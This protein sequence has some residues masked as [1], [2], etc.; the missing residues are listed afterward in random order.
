MRR[1]IVGFALGLLSALFIGSVVSPGQA[2]ER[3][4]FNYGPLDFSVSVRSLEAFA[5]DGTVNSDLA[6]LINRLKPEQREKF[7]SFLTSRYQ[8]SPVLMAQFFYSSLGERLLMYLG[9]L[10]QAPANQNGFYGIRAALI[11]AAA[12]PN[13]F[14]AIGFMQKF[15]TNIRLNTQRIL[16]QW[17]QISAVMQETETYI[18]TLKQTSSAIKATEPAID[19]GKLPNLQ[20]PGPYQYVKQTRTLQDD[21]RQRQ[22]IVDLYLPNVPEG[23]SSPL[24]VFTNGIG[25]RLDLYGYLAQHLAS[26]GFAIAIPQHPGSDDLQQQAFLK[27][28][29]REMF[30][31]TA[32]IDRPLDITYLLNELERLNPSEFKNQLNLK[33]VGI[34]GNSFGGDTALAVAGARMNFK[35]LAADCSPKKNLV[36]LSLLVQCQALQLPHKDYNFR[37]PRIKAASVLFPGSNSL[38]GQN[39]L[40][41]ITIPV[42]WGAVSKDIFSPLVL[43][44]LPAF[45][46]LRT[47]DKYLVVAEGID[48]LNLNFYALRTLKTMDQASADAVTLKAP[49]A[50]KL[51]LKALNLAFFQV[52]LADRAE[53]RPYLTASYAQAISQDSYTFVFLQSLAGVYSSR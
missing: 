34:F 28:M 48:H 13:G 5:K 46:G 22:F 44:Q 37:D 43:E 40:N 19:F 18:T 23:S 42:L 6:F 32:F 24:V 8:F 20:D 51:Y 45:N 17:N 31:A 4:N 53:Y 33:Q 52:Y 1:K 35:Q 21:S 36:N 16:Q 11:Q 30:Q 41:Q 7:R 25:T 14:S 15:P 38:Y 3:V 26:Y 50:A 29:S 2:A 10:I 27:G 49:E 12:D 39:G 9:E 47:P